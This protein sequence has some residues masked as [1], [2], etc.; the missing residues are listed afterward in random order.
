MIIG[1]WVVARL[2]DCVRGLGGM[3]GYMRILMEVF[4]ERAIAKRRVGVESAG[5]GIG[6]FWYD[7]GEHWNQE[8]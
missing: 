4:G 1:D 6:E 2:V 5:A 7:Y 8:A 3:V